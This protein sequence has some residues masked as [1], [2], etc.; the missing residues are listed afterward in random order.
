MDGEQHPTFSHG[1]P[2]ISEQERPSR[3]APKKQHQDTGLESQHSDRL[4]VALKIQ[5]D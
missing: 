3:K 4:T 2:Y 1:H 5:E